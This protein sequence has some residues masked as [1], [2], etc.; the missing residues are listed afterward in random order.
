VFC[1]MFFLP[2]LSQQMDHGVG[3]MLINGHRLRRL[4]LKTVCCVLG[5]R[6]E[7][8]FGF[9]H[10][11]VIA[12]LQAYTPGSGQNTSDNRSSATDRERFID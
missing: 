4:L 7:Y 2:Q 8:C 3:T 9:T 6:F 11:P 10:F 1:L 12:Q 5:F